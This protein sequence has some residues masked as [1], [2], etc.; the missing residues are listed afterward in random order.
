MEKI[1]CLDISSVSTGYAFF[2]NGKLLKSKCGKMT[3]DKKFSLGKRLNIF[4]K[5]IYDLIFKNKPDIV[6]IEDTYLRNVLTLK[7]LSYFHGV[8]YKHIYNL[9]DKDPYFI[10]A[11]KVRSILGVIGK[12]G[13]FDC[14]NFLYNLNYNFKDHNDITDAIALGEAYIRMLK[15]GGEKKTNGKTITSKRKGKKVKTKKKNK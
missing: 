13:A 12:Q 7:T 2:R 1:L 6:I 15:D 9:L 3:I 10:S 11:V 5:K 8:A 4:D 14:V